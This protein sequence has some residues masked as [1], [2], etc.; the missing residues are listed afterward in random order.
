G[1][2]GGVIDEQGSLVMDLRIDGDRSPADLEQYLLTV[3]GI[4]ATGLFV[5]YEMEV[6]S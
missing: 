5:G 3:P 4:S 2:D 1:K 6:L